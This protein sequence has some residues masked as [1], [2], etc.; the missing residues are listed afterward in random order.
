[1]VNPNPEVTNP[2][3]GINIAGTSPSGYGN[4]QAIVGASPE[5][6]AQMSP[7]TKEMLRQ[8]VVEYMMSGPSDIRGLELPGKNIS[9]QAHLASPAPADSEIATGSAKLEMGGSG[10]WAPHLHSA[11]KDTNSQMQNIL[12]LIK[13]RANQSQ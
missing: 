3:G 2:I 11:F 4:W 10:G 5:E 6:L 12:Q 9:L 7:E 13:Q 8:K 1:M